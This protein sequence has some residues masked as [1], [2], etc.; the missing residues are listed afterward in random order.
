MS[1]GVGLRQRRAWPRLTLTF[2]PMTLM[3]AAGFGIRPGASRRP[4]LLVAGGA[5]SAEAMKRQAASQMIMW[6][7]GRRL[8]KATRGPGLPIS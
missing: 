3:W 5:D 7:W 8:D 6:R 4:H 1:G 2:N